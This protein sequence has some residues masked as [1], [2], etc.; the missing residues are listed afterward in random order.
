[1][2]PTDFSETSKMAMAHAAFL[3][4]LINADLLLVHVQA[5]NPFYFEI[6]EPL[7]IIQNT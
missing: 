6:P 7:L 3:A 4:R 1:M 5:Y 2:V